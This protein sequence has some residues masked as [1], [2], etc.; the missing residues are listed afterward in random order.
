MNESRVI[1]KQTS[2]GKVQLIDR[3]R[4]RVSA[5]GLPEG[6]HRAPRQPLTEQ[7]L[8][9]ADDQSLQRCNGRVRSIGGRLP[10]LW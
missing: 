2:S 1:L 3:G 10:T 8:R 7:F 9:R 5:P 6:R 4:R